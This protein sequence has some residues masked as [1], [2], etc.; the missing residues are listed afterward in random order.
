MR[1]LMGVICGPNGIFYARKKVPDHL[2]KAVAQV[3]NADKPSLS[4]LKRSLGTRDSREANI[5]AKPVLM[6]FDRTLAKAE[7]SL[8]PRLVRNTLSQDEIRRM[9]DY[10]F[11]SR[12]AED[13]DIRQFGTGSEEIFRNV[14]RQLTEAGI[15]V[16]T[17]FSLEPPPRVWPYRAR[18]VQARGKYR[19]CRACCQGGA[20]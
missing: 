10:Y 2:T 14:A 7:A 17:P 11:A 5:L 16:V 13:D 12:L 3:L 15:P 8:K 1:V 4:W 19:E 6:E 9:A 18:N 20:C